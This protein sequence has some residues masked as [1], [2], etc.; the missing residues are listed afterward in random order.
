[1]PVKNICRS[2]GVKI[3]FWENKTKSWS[4]E[5]ALL[6][7]LLKFVLFLRFATKRIAI[8]EFSHRVASL[9]EMCFKL[10]SKVSYA[11]FY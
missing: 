5:T 10:L 9:S 6:W 1:M 3:L 11:V 8:Q 2:V 7:W 4:Q